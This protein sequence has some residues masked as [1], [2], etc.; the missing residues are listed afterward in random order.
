MDDALWLAP[1]RYLYKVVWANLLLEHNF[2]INK[3]Q[4][5]M[6]WPPAWSDH[7]SELVAPSAPVIADCLGLITD[8]LPPIIIM[9]IPGLT[10]GRNLKMGNGQQ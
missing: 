5:Q 10:P 1:S 6:P 8:F 7:G 3:I 9:S 4:I 2:D